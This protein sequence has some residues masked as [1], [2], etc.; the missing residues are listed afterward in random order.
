MTLRSLIKSRPLLQGGTLYSLDWLFTFSYCVRPNSGRI[1]PGEE[2]EVQ[3]MTSIEISLTT[4]SSLAG[5]ESR[6]ASRRQM[7]R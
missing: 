5:N 7:Q 3:G 1:E 4:V 6:R 2:I